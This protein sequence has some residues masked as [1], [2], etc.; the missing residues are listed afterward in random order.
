M[1]LWCLLQPRARVR[2]QMAS[3]HT[4]IPA[5]TSSEPPAPQEG[6][7]STHSGAAAALLTGGHA[8][9]KV[10]GQAGS[11]WQ[12]AA[13]HSAGSLSPPVG[14][15]PRPASWLGTLILW[16][17][18]CGPAP[19]GSC[20]APGCNPS[21]GRT[22]TEEPAGSPGPGWLLPSALRPRQQPL[23]PGDLG[24]PRQPS[25]A[26]SALAEGDKS[27]VTTVCCRR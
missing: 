11:G 24:A 21:L 5:D 18:S 14:A 12:P 7:P 27:A 17:S 20:P 15:L 16:L 22:V 9:G 6:L 10:D 2:W 8:A 26:P 1:I 19:P 13:S 3:P 4:G 23:R 25:A